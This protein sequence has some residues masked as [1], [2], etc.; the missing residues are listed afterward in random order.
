MMP[1][2]PLVALYHTI[3]R[4]I[5]TPLP[6]KKCTQKK[7]KEGRV[8]KTTAFVSPPSLFEQSWTFACVHVGILQFCRKLNLIKSLINRV[9]D[10]GTTSTSV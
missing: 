10:V 4:S 7:V 3:S 6:S 1:P 8:A 2:A 5:C 9:R